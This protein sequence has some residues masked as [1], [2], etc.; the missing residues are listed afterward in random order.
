MRL[1]SVLAYASYAANRPGPFFHKLRSLDVPPLAT[2]A[3][4]GVL[5]LVGI[6]GGRTREEIADFL[7]GCRV[8]LQ[9]L[10]G[11][12]FGEGRFAPLPGLPAAGSWQIA[13]DR[14]GP[15]YVE[16]RLPGFSATRYALAVLPGRLSVLIASLESDGTVDAQ[17]FL[18]PRAQESAWRDFL[19]EPQNVRALDMALRAWEGNERNPLRGEDL[20][21]LLGGRWIDPIL[22]CVAGYSLVR[23]GD[24]ER[25][26]GQIRRGIL[27]GLDPDLPPRAHRLQ[28]SALANLLTL[29]PSLPDAWVLAGLCDPVGEEDW[30][31]KAARCGVP[32]FAEGLRAL[33]P[34]A[35][36]AEPFAGLLPGSVWSAWTVPLRPVS[37]LTPEEEETP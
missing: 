33:G 34:R 26:L 12:S 30:F 13:L 23:A 10:D 37:D 27:D 3:A 17:Q 22:A 19:E 32:L 9:R 2:A 8:G 14:P 25:F 24:P 7:D 31:D 6:A 15:L 28:K 35:E 20:K 5:V 29:F 16:L 1:G 21:D 18:F 4:S 36:L 11:I